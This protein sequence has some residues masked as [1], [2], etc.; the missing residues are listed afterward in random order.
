LETQ[1]KTNNKD[2]KIYS[3][4]LD[5]TIH[6]FCSNVKS[7]K[8]NLLNGNIK[9]FR[10]KFWKENRPSQ[11]L[12]IEQSYIAN[13]KI[14]FHKL[15][16]LK[17]IYNKKKVTLVNKKDEFYDKNKDYNLNDTNNLDIKNTIKINYN[18][19]TKEYRLL[20]PNEIEKTIFNNKKSNTLSLDPGLRTFMTGISENGNVNIGDK[21]N[22]IISKSIYKLNKIKNNK[23]IS[24]RIKNKNERLINRKI[25]NKIDDLHWKTISY[26]THNYETVFLGDMSAKSIVKRNISI[27][28]KVQ[29]VA[30]LRT[31][32]YEFQ[33]RLKYK[34]DLHK[35]NYKLIDESY[36]SKYCSKCGYYKNDLTTEKIF[37]C[38]NCDCIINRDIN[39]ARN[40]YTKNYL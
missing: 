16:N 27:L 12:E 19:I 36:T 4:I 31:K 9:R 24:K 8:T 5:A 21:V 17:L 29:K 35:I 32:Y 6:Q 7:A 3:H 28:T 40:I 34:C 15:G 10:M 22:K 26:I 1:L 20:V 30:C 38:D 39:G 25:R 37:I 14:C 11:T 18:N 23:D 33:Q 2:T 13:N